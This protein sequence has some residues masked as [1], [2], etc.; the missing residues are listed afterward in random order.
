M[1]RKILGLFLMIVIG[2]AAAAEASSH[3]EAPGIA[4]DPTADNTDLYAFTSPESGSSHKVVLISNWIPLEKPESGPNFWGFDDKAL[5]DIRID[6]NGD[7]IEDISYQFRFATTRQT[8]NTF[9]YNTGA[10]TTL[11]DAD[12]NIRQTYTLTVVRGGA[13]PVAVTGLPV[14]PPWIGQASMSAS[15]YAALREEGIKTFTENATTC[16]VFVGQRAEQFFVDLGAAFDL[17]KFKPFPGVGGTPL[18]GTFKA[19]VH[20]IALEI[21]K[22]ALTRDGQWPRTDLTSNPNAVIGVWST[23]SRRQVQVIRA[24]VAPQASGGFVQVSRLGSPLVNELVIPLKDKDKFNGSQPR[25][26]AQFLPYVDD[27]EPARLLTQ[28]FSVTVP[29][30]PRTDL[31]QVFLTGITGI[32]RASYTGA[33]PYECIRLNMATAVTGSPNRLGV[34]GSDNQGYPNGRRPSDDVVD[35]TLRAA[36]GGYTLTP[37]FNVAPNNTLSDG[38][39]AVD[40]S[41][42]FLT[43]FPFLA[44]PTP[45]R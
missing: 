22:A 24:G 35:I 8:G 34:L 7:A 18:N 28:L 19:N 42:P 13:P 39:D 40:S 32:N 44:D 4:N 23:T 36:A 5:Y 27:P 41:Q 21:P 33:K 11:T 43:T 2:W 30:T 25:N 17:L 37:T 16:R 15:Q 26:D 45:G 1:K 9:L 3:R 12:L 31:E 20:T 10:V 38:V 29:P 6:N 14:V